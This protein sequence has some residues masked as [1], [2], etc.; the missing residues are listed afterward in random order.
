MKLKNEKAL[1]G[2]IDRRKY[3]SSDGEW[4]TLL[5]AVNNARVITNLLIAEESLQS[6]FEGGYIVQGN[7]V[8]RSTFESLIARDKKISGNAQW[9]SAVIL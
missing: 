7:G 2:F 5:I 9:L 3:G 6:S 4:S 8:E 1:I